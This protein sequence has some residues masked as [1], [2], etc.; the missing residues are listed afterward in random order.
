MSYGIRVSEPWDPNKHDFHIDAQFF[1]PRTRKLMAKNQVNWLIRKGEK[2]QGKRVAEVKEIFQRNFEKSPDVW[3]DCIVMCALDN[4]PTRITKDVKPACCLISDMTGLPT[5]MFEK[6][7]STEKKSWG[8]RKV[9]YNCTFDIV[10]KIGLTDIEF[11]L[12]FKNKLRSDL[13]KTSWGELIL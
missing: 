8:R 2:I 1:N 7:K 11:Q 10:M 13:L 9:F 12:W 6:H 4:P 5:E 3:K